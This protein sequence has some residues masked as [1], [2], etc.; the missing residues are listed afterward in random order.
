MRE[1]GEW[2]GAKRFGGGGRTILARGLPPLLPFAPLP[3][4]PKAPFVVPKGI[5][6]PAGFFAVILPI[7]FPLCRA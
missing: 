3:S 1:R 2:R 5:F 4:F 7:V 6:L